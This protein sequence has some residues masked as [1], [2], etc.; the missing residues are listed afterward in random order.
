MKYP[1]KDSVRSCVKCE[2]ALIVGNWMMEY[3][4]GL[5]AID[6]SGNTAAL[7][8]YLVRTCPR[9]GYQWKEE[10]ADAS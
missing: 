1:A 2:F 4:V 7:D 3:R 10:C 6:C 9:C 5:E 8:D